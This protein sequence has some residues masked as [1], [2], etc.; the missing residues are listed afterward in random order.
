MI[1]LL[2]S[3]FKLSFYTLCALSETATI[4]D[5]L[6]DSHTGAKPVYTPADKWWLP[7]APTGKALYVYNVTVFSVS[8][9]PQAD[10]TVTLTTNNANTGSRMFFDW[11][12][13]T[14]DDL[15]AT[16]LIL[17]ASRTTAVVVSTQVTTSTATAVSTAVINTSSS[18]GSTDTVLQS[19]TLV[20]SAMPQSP[21][22]ISITSHGSQSTP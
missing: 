6:G 13:Y 19:S 16:S 1:W 9:L 12:Q 21:S 18:T 20:S 17:S 3:L 11:A 8:G 15:P 7:D 2:A 14:F 4:D 5:E 22:S 10:H